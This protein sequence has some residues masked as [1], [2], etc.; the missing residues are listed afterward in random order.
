MAV[1]IK[2]AIMT[3]ICDEIS[4]SK[5]SIMMVSAYCKLS[6]IRQFDMHISSVDIEKILLV[7]FRP[8]DITSNASDLELYPYCKSHGWKLYF[9]LDLHAKTY[10]FDKV[11]C[12]IGSA[13][14]TKSGMGI[15]ENGNFEMATSCML[16][17]KDVQNLKLLLKGSIEMTDEIY[18]CM[19]HT[20]ESSAKTENVSIQ[21]PKEIMEKERPD[22]SLLFSEDFPPCFTPLNISMDDAVF[23]NTSN[24][25]DLGEIRERLENAK[26]YIWLKNLLE[27]TE[28]REMYFGSITACLHNQLLDEPKPY[29][30][31]V[32]ILLANLLNWISVLQC[33]D[34][35]IDRPQHSQRVRLREK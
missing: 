1:L 17:E 2:E 22:Y 8:E 25:T 12:I 34:I 15:S 5:E 21:W 18:E 13:N 7:R 33:T 11:R 24:I 28:E 9:R 19:K 30:K 35:T 4:Q 6:L 31:D 16:A 27:S 10:V 26:C 14:A 3:Q 29:R 32:K 20:I 23:L